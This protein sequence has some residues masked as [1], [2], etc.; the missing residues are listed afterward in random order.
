GYAHCAHGGPRHADITFNLP[1][2]GSAPAADP[3]ALRWIL[4]RRRRRAVAD[5][6]VEERSQLV[7]ELDVV[8][9]LPETVPFVA[10]SIHS[11]G[12]PAFSSAL[13]SFFAWLNG[14]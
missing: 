8:L 7:E 10:T 11:Y 1:P 6:L 2:C 14:T 13:R 5:V 12:L 4:L 9:V 3:G